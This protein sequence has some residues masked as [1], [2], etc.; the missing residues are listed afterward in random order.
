MKL[1]DEKWVIFSF[2]PALTMMQESDVLPQHIRQWIVQLPHVTLDNH[3][4]SQAEQTHTVRMNVELHYLF[5]KPTTVSRLETHAY[6]VETTRTS[7]ANCKGGLLA[8][9]ETFDKVSGLGAMV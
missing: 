7:W 2:L 9:I 1:Y 4:L 3:G 5:S 8:C 6:G